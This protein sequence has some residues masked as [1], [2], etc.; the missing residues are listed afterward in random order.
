MTA[1]PPLSSE[2]RDMII[3]LDLL[4]HRQQAGDTHDAGRSSLEDD[5]SWCVQGRVDFFLSVGESAL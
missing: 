3:L 2:I 1:D 5:G 4:E